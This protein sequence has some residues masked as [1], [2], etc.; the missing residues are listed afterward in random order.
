MQQLTF[1]GTRKLEWR[2]VPAPVLQSGIEALVRPIASSTC[3]LDHLI[4]SGATP[5]RPPFPLGHECV[6]EVVDVGDDVRHVTPGQ[7]VVIPWHI[8]CGTCAECRSGRP[9]LCRSTPPAASYGIPSPA[10]GHWGGLFDEVVRVPYADAM[11][12]PVPEGMDPIPLVSAGDNMTIALEFTAGHLSANKDPKVLV[13]A[14]TGPAGGSVALFAVDMMRSL[15]ARRITYLDD[16]ATRRTLA[17]TLGAAVESGPLRKELGKF[18]LIFDGS[19]DSERLAQA[20]ASVAPGG[21][22]ESAGGHF[23]KIE[24]DLLRMYSLNVSFH[25]GIAN[26]GMY[27]EDAIGLTREGRIR[28]DVLLGEPVPVEEAADALLEPAVKPVFV[29]DRLHAPR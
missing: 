4:I 2:D 7:L 20:F 22:I 15:G 16:S 24:I 26:A 8:N 13:L 18:D 3:D 12:V 21:S 14:P 1:T 9:A 25:I 23:T 17:A 5:F 6:A 19:L 11:L 28:P 29:R 27:V 10:T